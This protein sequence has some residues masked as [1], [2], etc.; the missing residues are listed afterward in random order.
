MQRQ[1]FIDHMTARGYET[2]TTLTAKSL[3]H[4][5]TFRPSDHLV[6]P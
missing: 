4:G 3:G 6:Q 2:A 1:T 5:K